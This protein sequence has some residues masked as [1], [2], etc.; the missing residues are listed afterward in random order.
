MAGAGFKTFGVGD[1][2]TASDV[3]TYLMQQAVM[4][5]ADSSARDTALGTATG[6]GNALSTGML[7]YRA[8]GT[9]V[10]FYDGSVWS[11]V[12]QTPAILQVVQTVKTDAFTTSSSSYTEVTG[13]SATITPA[14]D[15]NKVLV[16][17][18]LTINWNPAGANGTNWR[19]TGGNT[20]G[21]IGDAASNRERA[22][23][24]GQASTVQR[25]DMAPYSIV[26]LDSPATT[27]ATTYGVEVKTGLS[28]HVNTSYNDTDNANFSRGA[29][30]ITLLEVAA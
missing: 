17:V 9:A 8:D 23:F 26:Y 22:V 19:L 13:L 4:V 6:G 16:M 27:S 25:G 12:G 29:S 14:S 24:G 20:S 18:Q 7:S 21:Y 10:E 1:V 15:T 30:S 3:N 28:A 5:F 2:L 11:S